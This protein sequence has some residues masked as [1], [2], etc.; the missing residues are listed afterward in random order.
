MTIADPA[1]VATPK[2]IE[3]QAQQLAESLDLSELDP[4]VAGATGA[5]ATAL[6]AGESQSGREPGIRAA[7]GWLLSSVGGDH[8]GVLWH[9]WA[10]LATDPLVRAG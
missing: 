1:Q 10:W 8:G 4:D 2:L 3:R 9:G 7:R 6:G 5:A